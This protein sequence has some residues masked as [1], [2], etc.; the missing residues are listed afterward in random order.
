MLLGASLLLTVPVAPQQ[1]VVGLGHPVD[2][3][4]QAVK[5]DGAHLGIC[6]VA[7]YSLSDAPTQSEPRGVLDYQGLG[8]KHGGDCQEIPWREVLRQHA[9][10]FVSCSR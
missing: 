2:T 6:G 1:W 8:R 9:H 5:V 3:G 7:E 4:T 10:N